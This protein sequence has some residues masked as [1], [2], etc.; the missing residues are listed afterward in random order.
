MPPD[1]ASPNILDRA[2]AGLNGWLGAHQRLYLAIASLFSVV[3]FAGYAH[4][5]AIFAD[6]CLELTIIRL[7]SFR[8][9]L[10]ALHDN[11]ETDPPVLEWAMHGLFRVLGDSL[12]VARLPSILGVCLMCLCLARIAWRYVPPAYAAATFFLPFATTLRGWG[13][14]ARPYGLMLGFSALTLLCWDNLQN[15]NGRRL[16]RW[17]IAFLFSLAMTLSTHFYSVLILAPLGL[18]ELAKWVVRKRP[19]WPT[20][21]C[22]PLALVPYCLWLPILIAGAH[23]FLGHFE[24][25]VEF[26]ALYGFFGSLVFSLPWVVIALLLCAAASLGAMRAEAAEWPAI[27]QAH[28]LMLVVSC[29]FLLL[30]FCGY[31]GGMLLTGWFSPKYYMTA[32]FG[33]I[34]G[35]PLL[36]P[37]LTSSRGVVG[38][39]LFL[40]MFGNGLLV[41]VRGV[42]GFFRTERPYPALA[43]IR[44]LIPDPHPDIVVSAP[45]HFLPFYEATK[46][47]PQNNLLYLFDARKEGAAYG[48]DTSDIVSSV[49]VG[50]TPA[51]IEPFDPY[52]ATHRHFFILSMGE[53]LGVQEWQFK[54]L[55]N[56]L[57]ARLLWLG[58]VGSFDLYQVDLGAP[59]P[60]AQ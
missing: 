33:L 59:A 9:M 20:I 10:N 6:E 26:Q 53:V 24:D 18:G 22:L 39:C 48:T 47:D 36:L 14:L 58:K 54:Y 25:K 56:N 55:L 7:G 31:L 42:G 15:A 40:A 34:L 12:F 17:R 44:R 23:R 52:V 46:L 4:V 1:A 16:V 45:M 11:V 49:L 41:G 8:Q 38:L 57:H 35:L 21:L 27:S 32:A 13:S 37:G 2:A 28:R 51:R 19:D 60:A 30:P 3:A 43:E 5:R 29:G 50:R